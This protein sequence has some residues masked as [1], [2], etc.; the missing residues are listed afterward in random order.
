MQTRESFLFAEDLLVF[1]IELCLELEDLS[2]QVL[3]VSVEDVSPLLP[4][5]SYLFV[6]ALLSLSFVCE[7]LRHFIVFLF[8]ES[9]TTN[10]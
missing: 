1:L 4:P 2:A 10:V 9:R 5:L 3:G 6:C 7:H 8:F